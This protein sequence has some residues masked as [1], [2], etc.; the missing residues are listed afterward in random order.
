MIRMRIDEI[1]KENGLRY[2][3]VA[4]KLGVDDE[5]LISWRKSRTFPRLDM[6]VKL[7]DILNCRVD[8]LY[9]RK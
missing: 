8:D 2:N 5:T 1:I 6:A 9:D 3:Y 7:A 4:K